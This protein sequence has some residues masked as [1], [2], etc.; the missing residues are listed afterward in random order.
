M[1]KFFVEHDHGSGN[2]IIEATYFDLDND[3]LNFYIQA[4]DSNYDIECVAIFNNWHS[5]RQIISEEIT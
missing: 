4:T 5:V 1:K 2:C 3:R